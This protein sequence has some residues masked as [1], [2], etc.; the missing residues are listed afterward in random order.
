MSKGELQDNAFEPEDVSLLSRRE[1]RDRI[2]YF[3]KMLKQHEANK[4]VIDTTLEGVDSQQQV[5]KMQAWAT[6]YGV[7]I[8]L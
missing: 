4:P 6:R 2:R 7:L 8:R 3:R 1:R 5:F